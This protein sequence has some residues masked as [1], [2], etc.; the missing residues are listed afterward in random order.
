MTSFY[1]GQTRLGEDSPW[2]GQFVFSVDGVQIGHFMEVSGLSATIADEKIEEG[3]QNQYV[4]R[5]PGRMTWPN[6]VLK[7]GVTSSDALFEWFQ[8]SSGDGFTGQQSRITR[9]TGHLTL[10]GARNGNGPRERIREWSFAGAFPVKWSGPSLAA[11]S[12][13]AATETL[14]IAHNGFTVN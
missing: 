11:S 10:L 8:R 3:G 6:L 7:R 14:E 2:A 1:G 4:L 13:E 9:R 5:V 12:R